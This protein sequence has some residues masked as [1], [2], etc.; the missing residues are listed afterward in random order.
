M[1]GTN[2]PGSNLEDDETLATP[3]GIRRKA[4]ADDDDETEGEDEPL[5]TRSM[6]LKG[7]SG[8]TRGGRKQI[9][10]AESEDEG[11]S[12][13]RDSRARAQQWRVAVVAADDDLAADAALLRDWFNVCGN[14]RALSAYL[15]KGGGKKAASDESDLKSRVAGG[16]E[17]TQVDGGLGG[18]DAGNKEFQNVQQLQ[19]QQQKQQKQLLKDGS[20]TV[21]KEGA[22]GAAQKP[23]R[24]GTSAQTPQTPQTPQA[25]QAVQTPQIAKAA[26]QAV[27]APQAP[28][29]S[30]SP[31]EPQN[32]QDS[33]NLFDFL[34]DP[35]L[36]A[37][38]PKEGGAW[39]TAAATGAAASAGSRARAGEGAAGAADMPHSSRSSLSPKLHVDVSGEGATCI[40]QGPAERVS[41]MERD[42]R[43]SRQHQESQVL[44]NPDGRKSSASAVSV[45]APTSPRAATIPALLFPSLTPPTHLSPSL[46]KGS[47]ERGEGGVR[48]GMLRAEGGRKAQEHVQSGF[49]KGL[50]QVPSGEQQQQQQRQQQQQQQG[51]KK[52]GMPPAPSLAIASSS[53]E[54]EQSS[55][56]LSRSQSSNSVAATARVSPSPRLLLRSP[57][58]LSARRKTPVPPDQSSSIGHPNAESDKKD[59][60][61]PLPPLPSPPLFHPR[62][63]PRTS[64]AA[65][66]SSVAPEEE[67]RAQ[68]A[69]GGGGGRR[70]R[71]RLE[72]PPPHSPPSP[73]PSSPRCLRGEEGGDE[74][75]EDR[76]QQLRRLKK[77][78]QQRQQQQQQE[79]VRA[80]AEQQQQQ[81]VRPEPDDPGSGGGTGT[82]DIQK[83]V[84]FPLKVLVDAT[85]TFASGNHLGQGTYGMVYKA[86]LP[87]GDVVAVKRAKADRKQD[88][89][90]FRKE[91]ELLSRVSH[92]N[93]VRLVG[94][95]REGGEQ[96]LVYEY[97]AGGNLSQNLNPTWREREEGGEQLLVYEYVAGGN[98]SQNLNP[99][100]RER[101][102]HPPL[103]WTERLLIAAGMARGLAYLH[104][105]INVPFIHRDVKPS[106]IMIDRHVV[107]A[108]GPVSPTFPP[109]IPSALTSFRP[110][111]QPHR[112]QPAATQL[113]R[114]TPHS[115]GH[116]ER[117]SLFARGDQRAL[118]P[119][120]RDPILSRLSPPL[121]PL[122][123]LS[124]NP[125]GHSRPP[126]N[127]TERLLIAAGTARGLAYLHEEI[128]VPFIH[129]DVKPSN[130][131]ID[132]HVVAKI[133][134]FGTSKPMTPEELRK[135]SVTIQGT[136][137][138]ALSFLEYIPPRLWDEG[139]QAQ[140]ACTKSRLTHAGTSKPMT[141]EELRKM[142]VTIQGTAVSAHRHIT[143]QS[144]LLCSLHSPYVPAPSAHPS[145]LALTPFI[146]LALP[147]FA[148]PSLCLFSTPQGYCDPD[149]LRTGHSSKRIDVYSLGIVLLELLTGKGPH[150]VNRPYRFDVKDRFD[151]GGLPSIVDPTMGLYPADELHHVFD[152]ALR[153]TDIQNPAA[154]PSMSR[155]VAELEAVLEPEAISRFIS[156]GPPS[157]GSADFRAAS[158]GSGA[159]PGGAG[160]SRFAGA[161]KQV[162]QGGVEGGAGSAA[163]AGVAGLA[164]GG[165]AGAALAAAISSASPSR[166]DD[167]GSPHNPE[168]PN[169]PNRSQPQPTPPPDA[170]LPPSSKRT[171]GP[172]AYKGRAAGAAGAAAGAAE[173]AG[174]DIRGVR[175]RDPDD[176]YA[177]TGQNDPRI[178]PRSTG[179]G[180]AYVVG[181]DVG[182]QM[183]PAPVAAFRGASAAAGGG[184]TGAGVTLPSVAGGNA[185]GIVGGTGVVAPPPGQGYNMGERFGAGGGGGGEMGGE[186]YEEGMDASFDSSGFDRSGVFSYGAMPPA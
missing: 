148:L 37:T 169:P 185:G 109:F 67:L 149:Y 23:V 110:L 27:H 16:T 165:T 117:T 147:L 113:D 2:G 101:H 137:V 98:L 146:P 25:S 168:P 10:G 176:A 100:W 66:T 46:G 142:S 41:P 63:S 33:P 31:Q 114:K 49:L 30:Q 123:A 28:P 84:S 124:P 154:R 79:A 70:R 35:R 14:T 95:C 125:T 141:P 81:Q 104:E 34:R 68:G 18:T 56:K 181:H 166:A 158:S 45:S 99:T 177:P 74:E 9:G 184:A 150:K 173:A 91:I 88:A 59:V 53:W 20:V 94:Y 170:P 179:G 77:E 87:S 36:T 131:M 39:I 119:P 32:P 55:R 153:C 162:G 133:A 17:A 92:K 8:G 112:P 51:R 78:E 126:L 111:S 145:P 163:A 138:S 26:P 115:S 127:W 43:G 96:L 159:G 5:S 7:G 61:T 24:T 54:S 80:K 57:S 121:S 58:A 136:A 60:A 73:D 1:G 107:V 143:R 151:R 108:P 40:G 182:V 130:I 120:G 86:K 47:Q 48:E 21:A 62:Y 19:Q 85:N 175:D 180:G 4:W 22:F 12:A 71:S 118:H 13:R 152:L 129:R 140:V 160:Q 139:L 157:H 106:N 122:F 155:V 69:G 72:L 161:G 164:V 97:V 42:G 75:E 174:G 171:P 134:D 186:R 93:L 183:K 105:E 102:S 11:G 65:V 76:R 15:Q 167:A 64:G 29:A 128:N 89:G 50:Q 90:K 132:R 3:L 172:P 82:F 103:N 116:G 83:V 6:P 38:V 178:D 44:S 156:S 52:K 135:M 144:L